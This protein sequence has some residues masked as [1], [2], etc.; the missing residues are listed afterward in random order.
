MSNDKRSDDFINHFSPENETPSD[1][2]R[3][4]MALDRFCFKKVRHPRPRGD[5]KDIQTFGAEGRVAK[6]QKMIDNLP[7]KKR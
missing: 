1:L 2:E 6:L 4:N 3:S 5:L 7:N